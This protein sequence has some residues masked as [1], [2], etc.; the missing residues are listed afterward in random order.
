MNKQPQSSKALWITFAI[1]AVL[2]IALILFVVGLTIPMGAPEE[3]EAVRDFVR[4]HPTYTIERVEA[5][6]R[7]VV[8]VSYR[9]FY[10]I[11]DNSRLY[12][13]ALHYIH[14]DG[15]WKISH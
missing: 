4:E 14:Q 8:G 9:F 2:A 13:T 3:F 15:G 10:R 6:E 7:E 5:E 11:P 12:E 1:F